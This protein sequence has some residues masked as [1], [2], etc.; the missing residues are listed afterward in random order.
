MK[1]FLV[2][3][4][5]EGLNEAK[6]EALELLAKRI[7]PYLGKV[8]GVMPEVNSDS[9]VYALIRSRIKAR[10]GDKFPE[11][12]EKGQV[13]WDAVE[14]M[15]QEELGVLLDDLVSAAVNRAVESVKGS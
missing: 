13:V 15:T 11:I 4:L 14:G 6:D 10:L 5:L 2:N 3:L 12:A 9:L 8:Q 7:M 1:T